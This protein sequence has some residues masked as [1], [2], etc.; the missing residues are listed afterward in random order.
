MKQIEKALSIALLLVESLCAVWCKNGF[1]DDSL[2]LV[3]SDFPPYVFC[4]K[5][6]TA[7]I[8]VARKGIDIEILTELFRRT[9]QS[10]SIQC[11]PW[12]RALSKVKAGDAVCVFPGFKTPDREAFSVFLDDPLHVSQYSIFVKR[13]NEFPYERTDD[14]AGKKAGIERG[15]NISPAFHM[16][17]QSGKIKVEEASSPAQNLQK[18]RAGR[19]DVYINN[20]LVV[21]DTAKRLGMLRQI[22]VLPNP[23]TQGNPSYLMISRAATIPDKQRLIERLNRDL[24]EMWRDRT[25]QRITKRYTE[26]LS[27][28]E[29]NRR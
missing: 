21:L 25:V 17:A 16:A 15:H 13:G 5:D 14:L 12:K 10:Y 11:L 22:S 4:E 8:E 19:I 2:L 24:H 1:A 26:G 29:E 28:M 23:V 7:G 27:G 20:S 3:T 18:L 9:G 6:A